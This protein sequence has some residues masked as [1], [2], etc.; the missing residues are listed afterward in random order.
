MDESQG[1]FFTFV[2]DF[3]AHSAEDLDKPVKAE[4]CERDEEAYCPHFVR[5]IR[6]VP[7][8]REKK[9]SSPNRAIQSQATTNLLFSCSFHRNT[10][11]ERALKKSS[12]V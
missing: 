1:S 2:I 10:E 4:L 8:W 11:R 6:L 9:Q 12:Q 7:G 5:S 3:S